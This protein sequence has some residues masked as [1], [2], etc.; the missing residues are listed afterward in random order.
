MA[1]N[2]KRR[3]QG[4]AEINM[5]SISDIVFLLLIFFMVATIFNQELGLPLILPAK[6]DSTEEVK[7]KQ[8]NVADLKID[9]F[10][11]VTLDGVPIR[12]N[13]IKNELIRRLKANSKLVVILSTHPDAD[14]GSMVAVLDE[15]RLA[16]ARRMAIKMLKS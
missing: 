3:K 12:I 7:V 5:A 9:A 15:V 13:Q 2:L 6:T 10:N 11:Q 1:V 16:K 14:Y 8:S 4:V